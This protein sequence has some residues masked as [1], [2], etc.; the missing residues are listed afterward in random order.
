MNPALPS[1][2]HLP[3]AAWWRAA[4]AIV[5]RARTANPTR[6]QRE[7]KEVIAASVVADFLSGTI[8][9]E[10]ARKH[11]ITISQVKSMILTGTTDEQRREVEAERHRFLV[12]EWQRAKR[13]Q[14]AIYRAHPLWINICKKA[15]AYR[16]SGMDF[17]KFRIA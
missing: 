11:A 1:I 10:L 14:P 7:R 12:R 13:G 17:D 2:A 8:R 15:K 4:R 6:F 9:R 5:L 3:C 16:E